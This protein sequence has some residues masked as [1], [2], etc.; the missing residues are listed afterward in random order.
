MTDL[1]G[2]TLVVTGFGATETAASSNFKLH[3][4]L[5]V[6]ESDQCN[7]AFRGEGRK[8]NETI[9]ICAGGVLGQDSCRGEIFN[10]LS[11][12]N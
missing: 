1:I 11:L 5:N 6:V 10:E 9:Q 4:S 8:L 3:V 7:R 12:F 2:Q